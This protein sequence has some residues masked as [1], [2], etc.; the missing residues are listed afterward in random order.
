MEETPANSELAK[1]EARVE[2]AHQFALLG[3]QSLRAVGV[4]SS[5]L[6]RVA[7]HG[8]FGRRGLELKRIAF[9]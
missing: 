4:H 2:A 3:T 7:A 9:G 5:L 6:R 1:F 8:G